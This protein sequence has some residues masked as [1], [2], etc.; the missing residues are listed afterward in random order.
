MFRPESPKKQLRKKS[1][2]AFVFLSYSYPMRITGNDYLQRLLRVL[3]HMENTL[4]TPPTLAELSAIACFSPHHFHR[5][6]TAMTGE[7]VAA[8]RR[9]IVLQRA[10]YRLS[11][12]QTSVTELALSSGYDSVDAFSRAFRSMF[13]MSPTAYRKSG[14]A[15]ALTALQGTGLPLFYTSILG[16]APMDVQIKTFPPTLTLA[17]RHTG[18]Y[19]DCGRAWE[20][21]CKHMTEQNLSSPNALALSICHDDPDITPPEKCRMDVCVTLPAGVDE[22]SPAVKKVLEQKDIY[23]H[24]VGRS[25]GDYAAVQVRG[26]YSLLHSM[27]RSLYGQW[28]P[29]SGREPE[30]TPCIEVYYNC[31]ETTAPEDLL[32]EIFVPLKPKTR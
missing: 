23:L 24:T 8:Y 30:D 4:D 18:P 3:R 11:Y 19:M 10:A 15:P 20:H 7:S 17:T 29:Q 6:F 31:P 21:L 2:A 26:P 13:G 27:Y 9:R 14:G 22:T 32:T 1:R 16:V 12:R 5:I 25:D 28:L